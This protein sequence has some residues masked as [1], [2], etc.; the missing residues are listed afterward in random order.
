MVVLSTITAKTF[1]RCFHQQAQRGPELAP[2]E[3]SNLPVFAYE[4]KAWSLGNAFRQISLLVE[5]NQKFKGK[6]CFLLLV[7]S[8][9]NV[10]VPAVLPKWLSQWMM[11]LGQDC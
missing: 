7:F 1:V 4:D 9:S 10:S 5:T 11:Q 6:Q 2:K 8:F 3:Q